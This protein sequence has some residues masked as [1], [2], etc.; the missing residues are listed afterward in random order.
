MANE[1]HEEWL[2]YLERLPDA[3]FDKMVSYQNS[4]GESY[5]C[6][7]SDILTHV[8][9]HGTHTRAQAGQQLKLA[10]TEN[11][12]VTDYNYYIRRSK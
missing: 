2:T 8:I 9:N 7:V 3:D 6:T 5:Q 10:G 1:Y 11:L 4:L 12:P